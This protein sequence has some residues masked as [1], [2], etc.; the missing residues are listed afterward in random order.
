MVKAETFYHHGFN[1]VDCRLFVGQ[2]EQNVERDGKVRKTRNNRGICAVKYADTVQV[3]VLTDE[4]LEYKLM[5][6][7]VRHYIEITEKNKNNQKFFYGWIRRAVQE[8]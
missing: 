1:S 6:M 5:I 4:C 3:P 2:D 8:Q 7:N